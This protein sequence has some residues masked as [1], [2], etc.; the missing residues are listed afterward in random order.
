M[1]GSLYD[2]RDT[3]TADPPPHERTKS[4]AFLNENTFSPLM[5]TMIPI[6]SPKSR[7]TRESYDKGPLTLSPSFSFASPPSVAPPRIPVTKKKYKV[8]M[9]V[10]IPSL[11][12]FVLAVIISSI[13]H[14]IL[15]QKTRQR[16][17]DINDPRISNPY[18]TESVSS[19]GLVAIVVVVAVFVAICGAIGGPGSI[20]F[21]RKHWKRR[22]LA[23]LASVG[24]TA[25]FLDVLTISLKVGVAA[26]RPDFL[27]RCQPN[28]VSL[29]CTN[30]DIMV[31]TEGRVSFPS[32]HASWSM[33]SCMLLSLSLGQIVI[34]LYN[35]FKQRG[36]NNAGLIVATVG[37][38]LCIGSLAPGMVVAASR[39]TDNRHFVRDVVVGG[40]FGVVAACGCYVIYRIYS[41]QII[42]VNWKHHTTS[43]R[44]I[45]VYNMND[46]ENT[47]RNQARSP[48][49]DVE[50]NEANEYEYRNSED[51][52][53]S[54]LAMIPSP[55]LK[56]R[57][58]ES[59]SFKVSYESSN[60]M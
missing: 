42:S 2:K 26:L 34:S 29:E 9:M 58:N 44:Q 18:L 17:F 10:L 3:E 28:P 11:T 52:L 36:R 5:A 27:D 59:L 55:T 6:V 32:G 45:N 57:S 19:G 21:G 56:T 8:L 13:Y 43:S 54:I 35:I 48:K 25:G 39:V 15:L 22:I 33:Y 31:V 40:V 50:R 12:F 16:P 1:D 20:G 51:N 53:R 38:L 46:R 60:E 47:A 24:V 14:P 23:L 41:I 49:V 30:T 37:S 7:R 4:T